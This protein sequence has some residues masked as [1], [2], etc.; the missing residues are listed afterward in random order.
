MAHV[1]R[2]F[3]LKTIVGFC[4]VLGFTLGYLAATLR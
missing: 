4:V 1:K 3:M 2:H